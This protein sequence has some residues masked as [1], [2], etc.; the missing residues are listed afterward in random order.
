MLSEGQK[1]RKSSHPHKSSKQQQYYHSQTYLP[2]QPEEAHLDSDD[3]IDT[4]W[5][6]AQREKL[7]EEFED[8]TSKEKEFMT[9]WNRYMHYHP[10]F[11]DFYMPRACQRF[12]VMY[13]KELLEAQLRNELLMHLFTLYDFNLV[14]PTDVLKTVGLFDNGEQGQPPAAEAKPDAG[15]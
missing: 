10:I 3:D 15:S 2:I 9:Y 14:T 13:R 12:V 4:S 1:R 6:L 5:I 8:V 7:V 11:A